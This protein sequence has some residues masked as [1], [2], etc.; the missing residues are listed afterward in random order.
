MHVVPGYDDG[1]ENIDEALEMLKLSEA[2]GVTE[3]FCTSHGGCCKEDREEYDAAFARLEQAA[4][5]EKINVR[6]HKGCEI[7][8]AAAYMDDVIYGLENGIFV[9]L[10]DSKYVLA[11]LYPN[12]KPSEALSIIKALI[13]GG[14]KPIIAHMERNYNI[15]NAMVFVMIQ[16]GALI[17]VNANSLVDDADVGARDRARNLLRN[18]HIHFV[19]S[20]AHRIDFRSPQIADGVQYILENSDSEYARQ[21]LSANLSLLIDN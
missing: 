11:E 8:C 3:V 9:T 21:I 2:Q 4:S 20:D 14:Y 12:A 10:G 19:G 15:T 18:K 16:S 5:E 6:L 7:R 13:E 17:Q 1:A